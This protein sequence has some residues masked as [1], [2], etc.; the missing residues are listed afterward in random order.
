MQKKKVVR[1]KP[2][3]QPGVP[4]S[5]KQVTKLFNTVV[6]RFTGRVMDPRSGT[7]QFQAMCGDH[8]LTTWFGPCEPTS[9][10]ARTDAAA[11]NA[12]NP[13][14]HALVIGPIICEENK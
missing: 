11:H 7:G 1:K 10:K 3:E 8:L 6:K 5:E 14:H 2:A 9:E 4:F 12:A 13:G